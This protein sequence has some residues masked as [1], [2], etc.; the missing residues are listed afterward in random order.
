V[1]APFVLLLSLFGIMLNLSLAGLVIQPDWSAALLLAAILARRSNWVWALPAFW[2]HDL[3]LHWS[4]LVC[5]PVVAL[6]PILLKK[7]DERLGPGLPQRLLLMFA[8]LFPLLWFGWS[9][10]QWLLT[11]MV[12]TLAW[13]FIASPDAEPA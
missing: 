8:G 9:F 11:M 10:S 6:I 1:T 5:L 2:I 13:Y 12:C 3:A 7:A 4:S